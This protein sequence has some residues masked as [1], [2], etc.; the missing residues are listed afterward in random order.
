MLLQKIVNMLLYTEYR[1]KLN[2]YVYIL[3]LLTNICAEIEQF[4]YASNS[5]Q[6]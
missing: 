5:V 3:T 2:G 1:I 4:S 6:I